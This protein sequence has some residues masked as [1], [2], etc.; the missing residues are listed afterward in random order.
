M[1]NRNATDKLNQQCSK[2][3]LFAN[4]INNANLLHCGFSLSVA[5]LFCILQ[6]T[7]NLQSS[8]QQVGSHLQND[9]TDKLNPQ[10]SELTLYANTITEICGNAIV[11][12]IVD[13]AYQLHFYFAFCK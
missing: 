3:A 7:T 8:V 12:Y 5:F 4:T 2:L 9:A 13:L 10:C 1:Q 6:V 11:Y